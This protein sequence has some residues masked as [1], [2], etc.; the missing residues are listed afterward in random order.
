MV[1]EPNKTSLVIRTNHAP[2]ALYKALGCF[3]ERG[4]NLTKIQSRPIIGKAWHYM[5]YFDV[6]AGL[7]DHNFT[8]AITELTEQGC[9]ISLLG[10]YR[11]AHTGN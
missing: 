7:N 3:A 1:P 11:T 10:S 9:T 4:I 8:A 5:F 2:G 6:E